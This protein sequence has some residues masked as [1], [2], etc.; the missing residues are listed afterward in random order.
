MRPQ[1]HIGTRVGTAL[2]LLTSTI[3]EMDFA[4]LAQERCWVLSNSHESRL[5]RLGRETNARKACGALPCLALPSGMSKT[6][7][8]VYYYSTKNTRLFANDGHA[9]DRR[10]RRSTN[11]VGLAEDGTN[12]RVNLDYR[13]RDVPHYTERTLDPDY[14]LPDRGRGWY[15]EKRLNAT[16]IKPHALLRVYRPPGIQKHPSHS[17][18]VVHLSTEY[19]YIYFFGWLE[20]M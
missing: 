20:R 9:A 7:L 16:L 19:T 11:E 14:L 4:P 3:D 15:G 6:R 2:L 17:N 18:I 12:D 10:C 5:W 13:E 8:L 1:K